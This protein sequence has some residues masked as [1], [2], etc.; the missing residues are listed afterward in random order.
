MKKTYLVKESAPLKRVLT[1]TYPAFMAALKSLR[2]RAKELIE[3]K[4]LSQA[5]DIFAL[6]QTG[7]LQLEWL[8][9][10]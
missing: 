5:H 9:L 10:Q 3:D 1:K 2:P 8:E 7:H 6:V 4:A